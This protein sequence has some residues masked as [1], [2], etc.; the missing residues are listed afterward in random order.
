M[1][2]MKESPAVR[3]ELERR[4][5]KGVGGDEHIPR[6]VPNVYLLLDSK[7]DIAP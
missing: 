5:K 3:Q 4:H 6:S 2:S 7:A 1:E